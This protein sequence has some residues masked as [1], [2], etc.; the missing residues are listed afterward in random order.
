MTDLTLFTSGTA[1]AAGAA[2][3]GVPARSCSGAGS[4]VPGETVAHAVDLLDAL[5]VTLRSLG[6]DWIEERLGL[7]G[8]CEARLASVKSDT[9][10]ELASRDGEARADALESLVTR[11]GSGNPQNTTLLVIA[12]YDTT[13]GQLADPQLTTAPP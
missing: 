6:G 13:T 4:A 10:A 11:T 7:V 12:D 5:M 2:A 1:P 3:T 8:R 9:V